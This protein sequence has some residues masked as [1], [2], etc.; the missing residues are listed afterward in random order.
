VPGVNLLSAIA[1]MFGLSLALTRRAW[2]AVAGTTYFLATVLL[3]SWIKQSKEGMALTL[4]DLQF[5]LQHPA[6]NFGL[7]MT[8]P[9]ILATALA[10]IAGAIGVLLSGVRAERPIEALARPGRRLSLAVLA[11]AIAALGFVAPNSSHAASPHGDAY[12]TWLSLMDIQRP[13]GWIGRLN[14]FFENGDTDATLPPTRH[15]TRFKKAVIESTSAERPDIL[16]VF[17]ESTFDPTVIARC[18][19]PECDSGMFHPLPAA[20]R[21]EEGPLL[22]HTTGG[23]SWLSEFAFFSGFDWRVFGRGGRFAP[24]SLAP[25]LRHSL[26]RTLRALGYRTIAIYPSE[27]EFLGAETAY[28]HY[29]FEEFHSARELGLP[30]EW[31]K[32]RDSLVFDKALAAAN[33]PSDTRPVF[34]L[35]MTIRNHG[36]YRSDEKSIPEEFRG[37]GRDIGVGLA[38]YLYRMQDSSNDYLALA[39]RWLDS[40][41][42]RV[43]GWF[44]DHEPEVAW[45]YLTNTGD[46]N[47]ARLGFSPTT[48]QLRYI[49][50]YQLSSNRRTAGPPSH[51]G[52]VIDLSYLAADLLAFAGLPLD[53]DSAAA[54]QVMERC[55]GRMLDCRDHELLEDYLSY[56]IH[57]L[58]SVE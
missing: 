39:N 50:R 2:T 10:L 23:G 14:V 30:E 28:R 21:S 24:I 22:T 13:A 32:V 5:F 34:V 56:R 58:K 25:R 3:S 1:L 15:Q 48:D 57:D 9:L 49:T 12:M 31:F 37:I 7:F 38:D 17:E 16:M 11:S 43:V 52:S 29:G 55:E 51:A 44:G 19:F 35:A 45:G 36:P 53:S 27:G 41:R 6:Q 8:Y 40:P 26:P 54:L 20:A 33:L 47:P 42:S 4:G 18:R 46:L